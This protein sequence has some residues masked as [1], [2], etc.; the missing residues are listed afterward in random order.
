MKQHKNVNINV[1]LKVN[2]KPSKS[3]I[4]TLVSTIDHILKD[5]VVDVEIGFNLYIKEL[6]LSVRKMGI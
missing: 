2:R 4:N 6:K 5:S 1:K 3:D